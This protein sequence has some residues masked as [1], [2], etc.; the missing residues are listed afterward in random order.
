VL[1]FE[2]SPTAR[3]S[4]WALLGFWLLF[5]GFWAYQAWSGPHGPA[6]YAWSA[7]AAAGLFFQAA[8]VLGLGRPLL[9]LEARDLHAQ[10]LFGGL[11]RHDLGRVRSVSVLRRR[12]RAVLVLRFE[13]S[14]LLASVRHRWLYPVDELADPRLFIAELLARIPQAH[15]DA[16]VQRYLAGDEAAESG[17]SKT[18]SLR[19]EDNES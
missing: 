11:V 15:A 18:P 19:P 16:S 12:T 17:S 8:R 9:R 7:V 1:S 5:A 6:L 3:L 2:V 13:G 14:G 10:G 4:A